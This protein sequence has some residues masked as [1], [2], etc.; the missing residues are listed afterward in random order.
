MLFPHPPVIPAK[1]GIQ[2][3]ARLSE[4]GFAGLEDFQ[5]SYGG[6]V[7]DRRALVGIRIG[8]ICGCGEKRNRAEA[9][10]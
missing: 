10:S 9:E 1:A 3:A 6:R 7:C 5:D 4:S 8:G 2:R